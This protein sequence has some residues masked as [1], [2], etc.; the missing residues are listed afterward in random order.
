MLVALV[1]VRS[2]LLVKYIQCFEI[3]KKYFFGIYKNFLEKGTKMNS[4]FD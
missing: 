2:H 1:K 3:N 4:S